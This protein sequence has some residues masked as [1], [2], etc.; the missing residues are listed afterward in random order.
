MTH[1][2]R[3]SLLPAIL[4]V[5]CCGTGAHA[6][7]RFVNL[8]DQDVLLA[9]YTYQPHSSNS[10]GLAVITEE[11]WN[12]SGWAQIEPGATWEGPAGH[13][14]L[15]GSRG[16]LSWPDRKTSSG[17]V[18][19]E[20]FSAFVPKRRWS[21]EDRKLLRSGYEKVEYQE[22]GDGVWTIS[23]NRYRITSKEFPIDVSSRSMKIIS[24]RY[25][26]PGRLAYFAVDVESLGARRISWRKDS[27]TVWL[28]GVVEAAQNSLAE[29][30]E[31]G[32]LRGKL[33]VHYTVPNESAVGMNAAHGAGSSR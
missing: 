17:F 19:A 6:Q 9:G 10:G 3:R 31:P 28:S 14:Y 29:R 23:G 27:N 16:P 4:A 24:E 25:K 11:G 18:T 12:F 2:D 30:T 21:E 33:T 26:V 5:L 15:K 1:N 8:S 20:K 7:V 13:Y 32:Y 22:F